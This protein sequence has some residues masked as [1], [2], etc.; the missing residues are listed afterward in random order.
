MVVRGTYFWPPFQA[1]EL[2]PRPSLTPPT[3]RFPRRDWDRTRHRISWLNR[4]PRRKVRGLNL[5]STNSIANQYTWS[6]SLSSSHTLWFR[7]Q[8][9]L[10]PIRTETS[11]AKGEYL[12]ILV[13]SGRE[14][15]GKTGFVFPLR[16]KG[17]KQTRQY[18]RLQSY[19]TH[20]S[21]PGYAYRVRIQ[22]WSTARN[23]RRKGEPPEIDG[24]TNWM[25]LTD[26]NWSK[27]RYCRLDRWSCTKWML[28]WIAL[29][30][31]ANVC[32]G[33]SD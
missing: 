30:L 25:S 12:V 15:L 27:Q 7:C 16:R 17:F 10:C 2:P 33:Q 23:R 29:P 28:P 1:N 5:Y 32:L 3:N 14:I 31:T 8:F 4:P 20:Y 21:S 22:V 9:Q 18:K 24:Q 11:P 13:E 6:W 26:L 19:S